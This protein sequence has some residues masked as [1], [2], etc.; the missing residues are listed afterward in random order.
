MRWLGNLFLVAALASLLGALGVRF[1]YRDLSGYVTPDAFLRFT[2][3]CVLF[4]ILF[5]LKHF[6]DERAQ[7]AKRQPESAE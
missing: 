6:V 7:G 4:A 5:H 3:T 1:W 2:D